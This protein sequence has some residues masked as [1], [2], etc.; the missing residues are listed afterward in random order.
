MAGQQCWGHTLECQASVCGMSVPHL[1]TLPVSQL[2][3]KSRLLQQKAQTVSSGRDV[4][5]DITTAAVQDLLLGCPGAEGHAAAA[6]DHE[7]YR[8]HR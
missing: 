1:T 7:V 3:H 5:L 2:S 8:E 4:V 6:Y